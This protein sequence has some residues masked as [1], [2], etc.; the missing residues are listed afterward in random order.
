M[1]IIRDRTPLSE[2]QKNIEFSKVLVHKRKRS[3]PV[4]ERH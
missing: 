3:T 4:K 2:T 1:L